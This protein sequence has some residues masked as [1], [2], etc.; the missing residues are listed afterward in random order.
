MRAV[1]G[2]DAFAVYDG[3]TLT[4]ATDDQAITLT[5]APGSVYVFGAVFEVIAAPT[6]SGVMD[7][8]APLGELA[9]TAALEL[10][11]TGWA[12]SAALGGTLHIKVGPGTHTLMAALAR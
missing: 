7:G 11:E 2:D 3:T 12:Y 6:V 4:Q 8:D 1:P 10:A 5:L 9:D